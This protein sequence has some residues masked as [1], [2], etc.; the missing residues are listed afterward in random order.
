MAAVSL[1]SQGTFAMLPPFVVLSFEYMSFIGH[2][3]PIANKNNQ[4][5]IFD[6]KLLELFLRR[7]RTRLFF[8]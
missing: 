6:G 5:L 2:P 1:R 8:S 7:Q 3:E 4:S